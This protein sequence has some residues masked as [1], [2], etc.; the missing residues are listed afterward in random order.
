MDSNQLKNILK[1]DIMT[2]HSFQGVYAS[3]QLKQISKPT[4]L[5]ASYII[6]E[7][8]ATKSGSHWVALYIDKNK[9][10][11]Y[12][13][14]YGK[15]PIKPIE[16]FLRRLSREPNTYNSKQLQ[17]FETQT[18]GPFCIFYLLQREQGFTLE[19]MIQ[20]Y[21]TTNA[22]KLLLNDYFVRDYVC[23]RYQVHLTIPMSSE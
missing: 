17:S 5:P 9:H 21:F 12:F 19:K 11:E 3:D 23:R 15:L 4:Q 2:K 13:D 1:S 22:S 6:N 20:M 14:S 18:C 8:P 10:V 16:T 7:D